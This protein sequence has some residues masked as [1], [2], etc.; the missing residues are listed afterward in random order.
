V[1]PADWFYE[2]VRWLVCNSVA[3]GYSDGTF[4]PGNNSTRGQLTKFIVLATGWPLLDPVTPRFSDVPRNSPFYMYVETAAA[5]N[6]LSGYA[7]GTFRPGNDITRSQLC[8]IVVLA[9]GWTLI[10][11][12]VAAFSD[13]EVGS[14]FYSYVETAFRHN[15]VS[16]YSDS[17]FRPGNS[18][19]RAQLAKII[20]RAYQP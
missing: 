18:A 19:T 10:T 14:P 11:P 20:Q 8:K 13:V 1:Q 2:P 15:V 5:H 16:G 4:K 7:D 6:A 17:T 9:R 3:S 12:G